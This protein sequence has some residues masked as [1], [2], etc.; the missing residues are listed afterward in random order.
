MILLLLLAP[1]FAFKAEPT[2]QFTFMEQFPLPYEW[3]ERVAALPVIEGK[4]YFA[5]SNSYEVHV[6]DMAKKQ[7]VR[8]FG[9]QGRG[10]GEFDNPI[11]GV[12]AMSDEIVVTS[13]LW[14]HHFDLEG[15]FLKRTFLRDAAVNHVAKT[16]GGTYILATLDVFGVQRLSAQSNV[17]LLKPDSDSVGHFDVFGNSN[18]IGNSILQRY[19]V[20]SDATQVVIGQPGSKVLRFMRH[21][22]GLIRSVSLDASPEDIQFLPA[23]PLDPRIAAVV[24]AKGGAIDRRVPQ[25]YIVTALSVQ[26][27]FTLVLGLFKPSG[28]P[29]RLA[30][31][32]HDSGKT[33]YHSLEHRCRDIA[34]EN[35]KLYCLNTSAGTARIDVYRISLN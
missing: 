28:T 25:S 12:F 11:R 30:A 35:D 9:R 18:T 15:K 10:P 29:K 16:L 14:M 31:V 6:F 1:L 3:A 17:G 34:V 8:T 26:P 24:K 20:E 13:G 2:L 4:A 33:S 32:W 19:I 22:G 23:P 5:G 7:V 27:Q 21:D